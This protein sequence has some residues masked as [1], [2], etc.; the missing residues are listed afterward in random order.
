MFLETVYTQL[1]VGVEKQWSK[2]MQMLGHQTDTHSDGLQVIDF[3]EILQ[4]KK[5][6]RMF[7]F[8]K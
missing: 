5:F 2:W 7:P 8:L 1:M 6:V 4:V 3:I